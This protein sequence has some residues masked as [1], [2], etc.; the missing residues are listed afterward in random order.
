[1]KGQIVLTIPT[2]VNISQGTNISTKTKQ[3]H[4]F[5]FIC[6]PFL[7]TVFPNQMRCL[8]SVGI[9]LKT[10]VNVL[11]ERAVAHAKRLLFFF[12]TKDLYAYLTQGT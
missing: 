6:S 1:M 2:S 9:N 7:C 10:L 12:P 8:H 4:S 5:Y 3:N 11:Y